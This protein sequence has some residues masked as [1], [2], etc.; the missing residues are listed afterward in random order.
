MSMTPCQMIEVIQGYDNG[1]E[2]QHYPKSHNNAAWHSCRE[3]PVFNFDECDYRIKPVPKYELYTSPVNGNKWVE[4][5][6]LVDAVR[7]IELL[8]STIKNSEV[9]ANEFEE[10]Q[11]I[12]EVI[13]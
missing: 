10:Y 4:I 1:E 12:K 8:D 11:A 6:A 9:N 5:K 7:I 2:I 3:R 13:R